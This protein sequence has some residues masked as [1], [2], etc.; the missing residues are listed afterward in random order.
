MAALPVQANIDSKVNEGL[1][2]FKSTDPAGA[3]YRAALRKKDT[4]E[5]DRL[6]QGEEDRLRGVY[7]RSEA[8]SRAPNA[9]PAAAP[10]PT[11]TSKV[12]SQA[13]FEAT[14]TGSIAKGKTRQE[15]IDALKANGYTVK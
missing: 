1:Q 7:R 9:A 14:I 8:G 13:D 4:A 12:L 6:L 2:K 5:A 15:A 3:P 10:K 11:A